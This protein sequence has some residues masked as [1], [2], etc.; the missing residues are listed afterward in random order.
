MVQQFSLR[1][2]VAK[3][4]HSAP[5][6]FSRSA[7]SEGRQM[8]VEECAEFEECQSSHSVV[9]GRRYF[10]ISCG[11]P[12]TNSPSQSSG[13]KK[14]SDQCRDV[15]ILKLLCALCSTNTLHVRSGKNIDHRLICSCYLD[16]R[17]EDTNRGFPQTAATFTC[18]C[19]ENT[20]ERMTAMDKLPS[21]Q[22]DPEPQRRR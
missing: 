20:R 13:L 19:W 18:I 5:S 11:Y 10:S 15:K 14:D 17:N 16:P 7:V 21:L 3:A 22:N 9:E 6:A 12:A 1:N 8:G 4:S 2:V